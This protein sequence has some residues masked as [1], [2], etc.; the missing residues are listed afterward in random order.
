MQVARSKLIRGNGCSTI[1]SAAIGQVVSGVIALIA[2]IYLG[3]PGLSMLPPVMGP[4]ELLTLAI[5]AS[6]ITITMVATNE[7]V[8]ETA[9]VGEEAKKCFAYSRAT[10]AVVMIAVAPVAEELV[11]RGLI[12]WG[13]T[14]LVPGAAAMLIAAGFF[15][16][17]HVPAV[18]KK[19]A[20]ATFFGGLIF[21]APLVLWAALLPCVMLH[22]L[23]NA[24]GLILGMRKT[25]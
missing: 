3:P 16:A 7:I 22:A 24:V 8:K 20:V 5:L 10:L 15:G 9:S 12:Q 19:T 6:L 11:C 23:G 13:L 14:S 21:G 1:L 4:Q 2:I 17:I 18:G 25:E